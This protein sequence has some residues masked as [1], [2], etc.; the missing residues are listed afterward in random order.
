VWVG[1]IEGC[2]RVVW[3]G[4]VL[5]ELDFREKGGYSRTVVDIFMV[6][7]YYIIYI[8]MYYIHILLTSLST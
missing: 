6:R 4:A 7:T 2:V 5:D 8:S 1:G 3:C